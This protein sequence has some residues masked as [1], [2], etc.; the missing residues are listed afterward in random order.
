[1][2]D[3]TISTTTI[4]SHT[5]ATSAVYEKIF[6]VSTPAAFAVKVPVDLYILEVSNGEIICPCPIPYF[7]I[8]ETVSSFLEFD[9]TVFPY[10]LIDSAVA[11]GDCED[12]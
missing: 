9:T 6:T 8:T 5:A 10:S 1:M 4:P 11:S 7:E 3:L 12:C 2:A